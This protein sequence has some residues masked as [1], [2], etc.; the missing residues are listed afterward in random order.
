MPTLTELAPADPHPPVPGAATRTAVLVRARRIIRRRRLVQGAGGLA[1]VAVA[2]AGVVAVTG[3]SG[4]TPARVPVANTASTGTAS[5]QGQLTVP[6]G[7][8]VHVRFTGPGGTYE[9]EVGPDGHFSLSGLEPGEYTAV[10]TAETPGSDPSLG[11]ALVAAKVTVTLVP[12]DNPVT[13]A[14]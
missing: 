12:G 9:T 13:F 14:P 5:V 4:S 3:G 8:T 6:P 11:T 1:V 2:V 7:A 10:A